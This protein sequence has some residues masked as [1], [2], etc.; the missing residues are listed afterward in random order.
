[1]SCLFRSMREYRPSM[2]LI[3][4]MAAAVL[5]C[6]DSEPAGPSE[7]QLPVAVSITPSSAT[8]QLGESIFVYAITVNS[9]NQFVSTVVEWS[10]ANPGIATVGRTSGTVTAV[11]VGS[12]TITVSAQGLVAT[13]SITV[14]EYHDAVRI[15]IS[16]SDELIVNLGSGLRLTGVATDGHGRFTPSPVEWTS[17]DPGI[18]TIGKVDGQVT[19]IA[20]GS[21]TL[22]ATSGAA[23]ATIA[24]QVVPPNFLMQWA[25]SGTASSQH[26]PDAWSPAQATGPPNVDFCQDAWK[27]WASA[28]PD[29]D[30]LEL[31]YLTPVQPSEIRIYEVLTPGSIVKVEVKDVSG[32]YHAVYTALPKA[33]PNCLRM[34]SIPVTTFTEPVTAV[35]LTVDQRVITNW[36]GVD[37]VRLLGYRIN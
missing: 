6:S 33:D 12:T 10:S 16:P 8:L 13:A 30:W 2:W 37:A 28:G 32:A 14:K 27:A 19:G 7:Q 31:Q 29:L 36:N 3:G 18:A 11:G 35:R 5:S 9:R 4:I 24:V 23:R 25:T 21:T 17:V 22:V 20:L 26:E 34:L 1:M 15:A